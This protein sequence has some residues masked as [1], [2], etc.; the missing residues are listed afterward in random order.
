MEAPDDSQTCSGPTREILYPE[1]S[2]WTW[3][4]SRTSYGADGD[5]LMIPYGACRFEFCVSE[6]HMVQP[7]R[8][9]CEV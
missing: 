8:A 6:P 9:V 4:L 2:E 5:I 3:S 7:V 1:D